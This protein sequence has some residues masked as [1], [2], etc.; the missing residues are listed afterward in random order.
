MAD[1]GEDKLEEV[2]QEG[3]GGWMG[4]RNFFEKGSRQSG[5]LWCDPGL[6]RWELCASSQ[7]VWQ[8]TLE[9]VNTLIDRNMMFCILWRI[10]PIFKGGLKYEINIS[11]HILK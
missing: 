8:I 11:E 2:D 9:L 10:F 4:F 6:W 5:L 7:D 3:G 1:K